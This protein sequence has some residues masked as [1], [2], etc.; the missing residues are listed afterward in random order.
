MQKTCIFVE[1]NRTMLDQSFSYDTINTVFMQSNRKGQ[2]KKEFLS[3][4]YLEAA[5][6]Y[7]QKIESQI[8]GAKVKVI[9]LVS[10]VGIHSGLGCLALQVF[11]EMKD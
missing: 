1:N 9:D 7:A 4:E 2:V 11:N 3:A 6:E 8:E 10:A 5:K